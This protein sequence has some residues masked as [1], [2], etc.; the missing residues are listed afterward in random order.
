MESTK[1]RKNGFGLPLNPWQ[2]ASWIL[3]AYDLIIYTYQVLP[4]LPEASSLTFLSIYLSLIF[5]ILAFALIATISNP[6]DP[7]VSVY[8]TASDNQ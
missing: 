4:S 5:L 3:Y 1:R 7:V 2:I 8:L 6:T